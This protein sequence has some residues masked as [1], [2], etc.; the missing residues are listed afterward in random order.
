MKFSVKKTYEVDRDAVVEIADAFLEWLDSKGWCPKWQGDGKEP[1]AA[2]GD[3]L[4]Y[5]DMAEM[6][7]QQREERD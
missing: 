5:R 4:S 7:V 3:E 1:R 2:D 6:F